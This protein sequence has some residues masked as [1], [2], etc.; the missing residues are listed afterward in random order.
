MN[1]MTTASQYQPPRVRF[2][3]NA[4][5]FVF[6]ALRY[7]QKKLQRYAETFEDEESAHITGQELLE[8][9]REFAISRFGPMATTVFRHWGIRATDDFGSIVFEL[10]D[11]GEMRKTERD[12]PSDFA[13]LYDFQE[14]FE[15]QYQI[16]LS[17]AF[18]G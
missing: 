15:L 9:I 12:Q 1:K 17:E 8:G 5:E 11:K 18:R 13:D 6:E 16:N 10:I 2:H 14:V 3:P 4:Y 7:T